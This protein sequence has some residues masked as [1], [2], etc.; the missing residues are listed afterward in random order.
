M[1]VISFSL[2]ELSKFE[3]IENLFEDPSNISNIMSFQRHLIHL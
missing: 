1:G 2:L 3:L